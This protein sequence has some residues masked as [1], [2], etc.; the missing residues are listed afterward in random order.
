M[1]A[2]AAKKAA[3]TAGTRTKVVMQPQER[4]D[5]LRCKANAAGRY[6]GGRVRKCGKRATC[7]ALGAGA[8]F[9]RFPRR[10]CSGGAYVSSRGPHL[11]PVSRPA[12]TGTCRTC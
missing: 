3:A 6:V 1:V 8:A 9:W 2:D 12:G 5:V 4:S 7:W 11:F 10:F